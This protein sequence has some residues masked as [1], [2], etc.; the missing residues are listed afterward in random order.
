MPRSEYIELHFLFA[1]LKTLPWKYLIVASMLMN[2]EES[3]IIL[4]SPSSL[5][6]VISF[7]DLPRIKKTADKYLF[8][9]YNITKPW[10][11]IYPRIFGKKPRISVEI[12]QNLSKIGRG[13]VIFQHLFAVFSENPW[14][15]IYSRFFG[16]PRKK[17]IWNKKPR[18]SKSANKKT[19][20]KEDGL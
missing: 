16:N 19:A 12:S 3:K 4:Y 7:W 17:G 14:I 11:N 10:I 5:F 6:A 20:N 9:V 18:I 13:F 1:I 15:N 8:A 2:F